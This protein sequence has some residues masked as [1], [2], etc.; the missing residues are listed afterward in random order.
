MK[1][2]LLRSWSERAPSDAAEEIA[3]AA[4]TG[5]ASEHDLLPAAAA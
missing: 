1:Q 3:D 4:R 5:N 2:S